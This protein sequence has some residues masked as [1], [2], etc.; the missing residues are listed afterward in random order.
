MMR[1]YELVERV[2]AY[3]PNANEEILN[4]A[5]VYAM[6]KHGAQKRASGDPYFSH[7]LEV[8]G[9]LTSMRLDT[10]T[11]ATA[12]LHDTLEDTDATPEEIEK[13]F[14]TDILRLVQGVTKLS[15][16]ES[17]A[18][19]SESKQAENFRKLVLAMSEDIR[20]LLVKLADRVHNMRTLHFIP[21]PEKRERIARETLEIYAPLSE[22]IGMHEIKDELQDLAFAELH[23]DARE[24]IIKRLE[25]LRTD[26]AELVENITTR[27]QADLEAAGV[28]A[29][30]CGREKKPYS[31]WRKMQRNNVPMEALSDIV[32]FRVMVDTTALCY[33]ALGA[34][35]SAYQIIPGRF[36]DYISVP[37]PNGYQSLHTTLIGPQGHRIEVQ[38]RT[39]DMHEVAELGVAAHWVYKQGRQV[40]DGKQ[41]RWLR[42]LLDV[43]EQA[44]NP[45]EFLEHTKIAMFHDQV[46]CFS[47]KGDLVAL[48]R[49]ATPVDFAYAVHSAVGDACIGAR[50]NARMVPLRTRLKNGDQVEILTQ[51]GHQP[52]PAW[53][54]FVVTAKARSHIR[55]FMRNQHR[56]QYRE[57]G[58]GLLDKAFRDAGRAVSDSALEGILGKFSVK[59]VEDLQ[60]AVGEGQAG[61]HAV[62]TAIYPDI[63]KAEKE[64]RL[65]DLLDKRQEA[66]VTAETKARRKNGHAMP[67]KGLI[68]G[69]AM[70][71]A[72]CCHPVPGDRIVGIIATGKGVT[73]HTF[74]CDNLKNFNDQ[75]ERWIDVDWEDQPAAASEAH[76]ARLSVVV[77]N[78]PG[79]LGTLCTIIGQN[80][81]NIHNLKVTNRAPDLWEML[82][83][84]EVRDVRHLGSIMAAL[85]ASRG[86]ATVERG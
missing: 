3:D 6:K 32:A 57:L 37:K 2:K 78:A 41:Y 42:E 36:K 85:R 9:I 79:S 4:R 73:I 43:L 21:K 35:H 68:P 71:F 15:Q 63:S 76:V 10:S 23:R 48:P 25:F 65:S 17:K 16:I 19:T 81:G 29:V 66:A 8:A 50:V 22:R 11:I 12:L 39:H 82:L 75:P 52:S 55:R 28:P 45:E 70:H 1:Q 7:P 14:G 74:D 47:P 53:E 77:E 67:I 84:V 30:V 49:D 61:A 27:L 33:A 86:I 72:G 26:G 44:S 46:F 69:M 80:K 38:I 18:T 31:I 56:S 59:T 83:D 24:S 51:K 64:Q 54:Q 20:V 5:Y 34:M 58:A 40:E 60:V 62:L 13:L